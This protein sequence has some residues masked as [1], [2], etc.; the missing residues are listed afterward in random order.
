MDKVREWVQEILQD[1]H[2]SL[3]VTAARDVGIDVYKVLTTEELEKMA[4][5]GSYA[6]LAKKGFDRKP[7]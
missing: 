3:L 7:Q 1:S 4:G 6:D 2:D 5:K